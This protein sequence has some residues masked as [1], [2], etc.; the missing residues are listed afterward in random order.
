MFDRAIQTLSALPSLVTYLDRDLRYRFVN[1]S[2]RVWRERFPDGVIGKHIG[3][4]VPPQMREMTE[5]RMREALAGHHVEHEFDAIVRGEPRSFRI[6]YSPDRDQ[7]GNVIGLISQTTDLT[8]RR[9][10]EQDLRNSQRTFDG[11]FRNAVIGKA[12]VDLDGRCSRVN[13]ALARMLGYDADALGRMHFRDF[14]H[15]DDVEADL[16][17]FQ[18]LMTGDGE[19]YQIEKRYFHA[20]GRIVHVLLSVSVVRDDEGLPLQ[21]VSEIVDITERKVQQ[22]LDRHRAS[23]DPLTA[24]LNRRGFDAAIEAALAGP[25]GRST[26]VGI[27]AIDLDRFKPVNDRFGHA[28]GDALLVE[29]GHRLAAAVRSIDSVA[30]LGGDEFAVLLTGCSHD[31]TGAAAAR[32]VETLARPYLIDQHEVVVSAS[33]GAIF[34]AAEITDFAKLLRQADAELYRAKDAGRGCWRLSGIAA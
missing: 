30:R 29:A 6:S 34:T 22:A 31:E 13:D 26:G 32:M 28:A 3:E 9:K 21:F 20:D 7:D 27:L 4:V 5:H 23:T 11:A 16:A 15:P 14:T 33:V 24:L 12:V 1:D 19:G 2:Q 10:V 8:E 25:S 18:N 17:Q